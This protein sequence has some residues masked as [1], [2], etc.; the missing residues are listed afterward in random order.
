MAKATT[1]NQLELQALKSANYTDKKVAALSESIIN[2]LEEMSLTVQT[3]QITGGYRLTIKDAEGTKTVDV[4]NGSTPE[5][6]VDYFT[7]ADK[8]EL[9]SSVI[10]ALPVYD[11]SVTSV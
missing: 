10:A 9:V 8:A 1:F 11:G 2:V 5:K 6:G 4:M 3:A 7:Q